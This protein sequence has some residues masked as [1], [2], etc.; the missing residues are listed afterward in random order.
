MEWPKGRGTGRVLEK[1]GIVGAV[2]GETRASGVVMV[3]WEYVR[4]LC[5]AFLEVVM[6]WTRS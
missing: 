3:R 6:D 5:P 1:S 4:A 2:L